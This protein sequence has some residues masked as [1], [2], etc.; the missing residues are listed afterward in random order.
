VRRA[1]S[2]GPLLALA[3]TLYGCGGTPAASR[4]LP[5]LPTSVVRALGTTGDAIVP[6][7]PEESGA[8]KAATAASLLAQRA[9]LAELPR[10][11]RVVAGSLFVLADAPGPGPSRVLAWV[12]QTVPK[13]G[14]PVPSC[15]PPVSAGQRSHC[16]NYNLRVDFVNALTDKWIMATETSTHT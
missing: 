8:V 11:S 7:G 4:I 10:E 12:L 15:G 6:A 5:P 3:V 13:G 1:R 2:L 9:A 14:Y 16:P